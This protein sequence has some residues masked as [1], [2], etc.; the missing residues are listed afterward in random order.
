MD[1]TQCSA[2]EIARRV[3]RREISPV[4]VVNAHLRR[5]DEHNPRLNAFVSVRRE[6]VQRE[7]R[8]AE[9]AV[10]RGEEKPLLGVPVSIKSSIDVA[11]LRCEAGSRL[12]LGNIP[13]QD[14]PLVKR[15]KDAGAIVL[16]NTNAAELLMA[17]DTDNVLNGRTSNPWDLERTPGGSSGGESA[18]VASGMSAAGIG[19][20]GGGSIRV[21][22]HY[23]GICGLKTTPGRIPG[24][25]H[26]PPCVGPFA[27]VGVVGP[28]ARNAEDLRLL[29]RVTSGADID[30]PM[31]VDY[32]NPQLSLAELRRIRVGFFDDDG[33]TPVTPETKAAVR[34][35][36]AALR[37]EGMQVED[38]L[39]SC[40]EQ[41]HAVWET[42]FVRVAGG[43][44]VAGLAA[45]KEAE[46]SP[47]LRKFLTVAT[48]FQPLTADALLQT[49]FE[50]DTVR[51]GFL[52]QM[53][54]Y[55]VLVTPVSTGPAFR[56]GE[57]GWDDSFP[58]NYLRSMRFTQWFNLLGNP[59]VVVPVGRSAQGLPI[60]VQIVGRPYEEDVIL[61]VAEMLQKHFAVTS[62]R[63]KEVGAEKSSR[64]AHH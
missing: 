58:V 47:R 20:D 12:R 26:F 31:A 7:A 9:D 13:D 44:L 4:E 54:T 27:H 19:S 41:A 36:A 40:L 42:L 46:I 16:G 30:D 34:A 35:A 3:R 64:S 53:D 5:I 6:Q 17:Y 60:G 15:L 63:A 38:Y 37:D 43:M 10:M 33:G 52:R 28:M 48:S 25:G 51:A 1:I 23:A 57:G 8:L 11:G 29:L 56:H 21:P 50:R 24:T 61:Q 45:G 18:A 14:A 55:R 62:P 22:A 32:P 59:A 49:L 39:P 2:T